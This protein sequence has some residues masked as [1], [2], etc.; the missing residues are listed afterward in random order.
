MRWGRHVQKGCTGV[1]A[2]WNNRGR[3]RNALQYPWTSGLRVG[4]AIGVLIAT[5]T[6]A[7]AGDGLTPNTQDWVTIVQNVGFPMS[8]ASVCMW[9]IVVTLKENTKA[10]YES[11]KAQYE[12]AKAIGALKDAVSIQNDTLRRL[13]VLFLTGRDIR[14]GR[15]DGSVA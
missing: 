4:A 15:H 8:I 12:N 1:I 9:V 10:Q 14:Q 7:W 6:K 11:A 13:E 5:V 3:V 2:S